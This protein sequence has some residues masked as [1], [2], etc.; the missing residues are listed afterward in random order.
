MS[1]LSMPQEIPAAKPAPSADLMLAQLMAA[2]GKK[3]KGQPGKKTT[4]ANAKKIELEELPL[5]L[6]W[7]QQKTGYRNWKATARILQMEEQTCKCCGSV[8]HAV[9]NELFELENT[10]AHSVWLRREGFGIEEPDWLPLRFVDLEPRE[11]SG[12]SQCRHTHREG[13]DHLLSK[14]FDTDPRQLSLPL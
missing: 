4:P 11:V 7:N 6:R 14:I 9:K 1:D 8:T 10:I 3:P 12:C 2:F 5:H 13:L